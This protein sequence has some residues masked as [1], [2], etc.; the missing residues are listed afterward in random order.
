MNTELT[1]M[2][3]KLIINLNN[4]K[5]DSEK[6]RS[7]REQVIMPLIFWVTYMLRSREGVIS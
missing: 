2:N 5:G 7:R 3:I 4:M 1:N 6:E